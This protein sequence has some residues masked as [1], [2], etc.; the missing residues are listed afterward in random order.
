MKKDMPNKIS[1]SSEAT[2]SNSPAI[3]IQQ[4]NNLLKPST[5]S[6]KSSMSSQYEFS[7]SSAA[8]T[9]SK[10]RSKEVNNSSETVDLRKTKNLSISRVY[11]QK[12][13]LNVQ[14]NERRSQSQKNKDDKRYP[15]YKSKKKQASSGSEAEYDNGNISPLYSNW[16]QVRVPFLNPAMGLTANEFILLIK[17]ETQEHLL[18]LQHYIIEQAKLSGSYHFGDPLDSDSLHSDTQSEHS[19]S[20]HEPDNEDSDHSDGRGDYLAHHYGAFDEY[21]SYAAHGELY[22]NV[23]V[24]FPKNQKEDNM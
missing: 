7:S 22:Y 4:I 5:S 15:S 1:P 8:K 24:G 9:S 17:Q 3:S 2:G 6:N 23:D 10:E 12:S 13:S 19:F 18:P 11:F 16:D 21:G 14:S 20:G